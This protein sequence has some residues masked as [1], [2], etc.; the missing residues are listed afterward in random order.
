MYDEIEGL[1]DKHYDAYLLLS[2][3]ILGEVQLSKYFMAFGG[4]SFNWVA[5]EYTTR[6]LNNEKN[7]IIATVTN[8]TTVNL[9]ARFEYGRAA[10]ELAFEKTFLENPFGAFSSTDGIVSSLG[11]FIN[12]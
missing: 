6:E 10:L 9:G 8:S 3:N 11:A 5:A 1:N 12:F 7:E 4:A 2:P